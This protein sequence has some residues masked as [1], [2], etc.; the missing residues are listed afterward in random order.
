M[1][2]S[3]R[4]FACGLVALVAMTASPAREADG[5]KAAPGHPRRAATKP[6]LI[7]GA[8]EIVGSLALP[9]RPLVISALLVP[10]ADSTGPIV[11]P[12]PAGLVIRLTDERGAAV[13]IDFAAI[14]STPPSTNAGA[15]A[16]QQAYWLADE[17]ATLRL[18]PGRYRVTADAG[19]AIR[20]S[21]GNLVVE[22]AGTGAERRAAFIRIE[23]GMLLG[24]L[25]DA[26]NEADR[27]VAAD[28]TDADAWEA[29]GELLLADDRSEEASTAFSAARRVERDAAIE[30]L[31]L[32]RRQRAA[33]FRTMEKRGRVLVGKAQR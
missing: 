32:A 11:V 1:S 21:S 14:A 5:A 4:F 17:A 26:L 9:G 13:T 16:P 6:A 15:D 18:V 2:A 23:R 22:A 3:R 31:E 20:V 28:S 27:L 19:P 25:P 30:T 29:R 12:L 33:I 8:N 10:G 7:L 24:R